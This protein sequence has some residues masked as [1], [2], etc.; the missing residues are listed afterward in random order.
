MLNSRH[1]MVETHNVRMLREQREA[2][3]GLGVR[4]RFVKEETEPA[5]V[6]VS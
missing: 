5:L 6:I 2:K 3:E 1:P 4:S